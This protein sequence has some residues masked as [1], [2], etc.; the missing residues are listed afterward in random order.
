MGIIGEEYKKLS[1]ERISGVL[2]LPAPKPKRDV[3]KLQDLFGY[4]KLWLDQYMHSVKLFYDKLVAPDPIIWTAED[5]QLES[6]KDK[7]PSAPVLSLP[8]LRKE[9]DLFMGAEGGIAYG[10]LTQDR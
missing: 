5:E 4:C 2:S 3:R 10:V 1:P 6:L 9:F 7:L 8:D